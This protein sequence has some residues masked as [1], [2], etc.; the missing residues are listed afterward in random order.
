M[1]GDGDAVG[2]AGQI[3]QHAAWPAEGRFDVDHP[4]ELGGS[5][6]QSLKG[7]RIRERFQFAVK[8]QSVVSKR[9]AE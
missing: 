6:A 3:L 9:V 8:M 4:I 7:C 5:M 2:V 1:I